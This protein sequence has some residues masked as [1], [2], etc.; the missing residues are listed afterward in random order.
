[1]VFPPARFRFAAPILVVAAIG[2]LAFWPRPAASAPAVPP[3]IAQAAAQ[4]DADQAQIRAL[5]RQ[6]RQHKGDD[7]ALKSE[8]SA[9]SPIDEGLDS[10]LAQLSPYEADAD[11]RL[12][13]L[14][15]APKPGAAPEAPQIAQTRASVSRFRG[16]TDTQ[17]KRARL[18]AVEVDQLESSIQA[19]RRAL[20][21]QRLWR[22]SPAIFDQAFWTA[23][24]SALAGDIAHVKSVWRHEARLQAASHPSAAAP[25]EMA[26]AAILALL[27][28]VAAR[29]LL[30]RWG[31]S[32][33]A[34]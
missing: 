33:I 9:L 22:R 11:R 2:L 24:A 6:S 18:L 32:R 26:A 23:P 20:F 8:A 12:A 31:R 4:L 14:G 7:A 16:A 15:P 28:L 13:Q 1:M 34:G 29:V 21:A 30:Q 17:I 5:G 27:I 3:M 25:E 19:Q 10:L